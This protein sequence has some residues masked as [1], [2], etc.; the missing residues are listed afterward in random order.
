MKER[1]LKRRQLADKVS[2]SLFSCELM[3]FEGR[4]EMKVSVLSDRHS[5]KKKP[6]VMEQ[7]PRSRLF[8][9]E[10]KN[11]HFPHSCLGE[12]WWLFDRSTKSLPLPCRRRLEFNVN[13]THI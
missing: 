8:Q 4:G 5:L 2:F 3:A 6:D 10:N 7:L 13:C 12:L 1:K 11:P 9:V